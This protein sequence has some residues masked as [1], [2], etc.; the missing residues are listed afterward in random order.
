M[1]PIPIPSRWPIARWAARIGV[2]RRAQ[3][4]WFGDADP[5][6]L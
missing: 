5:N 1:P 4:L 2:P 6:I 3:R